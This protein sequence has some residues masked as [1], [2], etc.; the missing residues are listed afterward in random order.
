MLSSEAVIEAVAAALTRNALQPYVCDP[1][2]FAKSGDALLEQNAVDAMRRRLIPLATIVTPN[3]R[4][5]AALTGVD[6]AAVAPDVAAAKETAKRILDLGANSAVVKGIPVG[7][8]RVDLFFDGREFIEF[9]GK[10]GAP[11]KT[12]GSG[13]AFS[14]A[15]TAGLAS[16]LELVAAVDQAKRLVTTAIELSE[17]KGRGT[18]SVNVLAFKPA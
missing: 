13:C 5:A 18:T 16:G 8:D 7:G 9:A 3:R 15:I 2:M 11:G 1:V 17:A 14:A 10:A 12:H 4:E 6:V